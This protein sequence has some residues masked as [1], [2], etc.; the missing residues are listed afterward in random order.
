ME[1]GLVC[2][3][4]LHV[5]LRSQGLGEEQ[6]QACEHEHVPYRDWRQRVLQHQSP[7]LTAWQTEVGVWAQKRFLGRVSAVAA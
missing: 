2:D 5:S 7:Q 1:L 6:V 4:A 3:G